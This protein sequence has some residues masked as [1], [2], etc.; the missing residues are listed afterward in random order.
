MN[1]IE[2]KLNDKMYIILKKLDKRAMQ[3][4]YVILFDYDRFGDDLIYIEV[5][6]KKSPFDESLI[7]DADIVDL[8]KEYGFE[9]KKLVINSKIAKEFDGVGML[10]IFS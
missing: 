1:I 9:F 4:G 3:M 6:P 8:L 2:K 7:V 5:V 10:A